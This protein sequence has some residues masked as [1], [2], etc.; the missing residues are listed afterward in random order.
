MNEKSSL[1]LSSIYGAIKALDQGAY[2]G[3]SYNLT[4][5]NTLN[6]DSWWVFMPYGVWGNPPKPPQG[7]SPL[8]SAML[9]AIE[10]SSPSRCC[11]DILHLFD[12]GGEDFFAD[13]NASK[14]IATTLVDFLN[15]IPDAET[16]VIRYLVGNLGGRPDP[17][18]DGFMKALFAALGRKPHKARLFFGNFAPD[19]SFD[20]EL[21][22]QLSTITD[23]FRGYLDSEGANEN[24][25]KYGMAIPKELANI[26]ELTDWTKQFA[27]YILP[28]ASWNHAKIFA[29]N[30]CQL[31]TGGANYWNSW[32][33][34][35]AKW[36]FDLSMNV[37]GDTAVDAHQF[38]NYLWKYLGDIPG[39]DKIS[40]CMENSTGKIAEWS[41]KGKAPQF[42]DFPENVGTTAALTVARNGNWPSLRGFPMQV[43]DGIRDF[44]I[45]VLAVV[46]ETRLGP[47]NPVTPFAVRGLDDSNA[48]FRN[49]LS[50]V[51]INPAAWASRYARNYAISQAQSSVRFSQQK[52]VMD[53]L[54]D[55]DTYKKLIAE[56]NKALKI[57]WNGYVWP[58]DTLSA[59]GYA[60]ANISRS[61]PQSNGIQIV[62]STP[63]AKEN[64]EDPVSGQEFKSKLTGMMAG[65]EALG[66]ITFEGKIPDIVEKWLTY[67]RVDTKSSEAEHGNHSKLVVVDDAVCY[68][69]S[70][71][72]YPCYN[73]EFG[74]WIDDKQA[75]SSFVRDYWNGLW[76]FARAAE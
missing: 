29:I 52:F 25:G 30:G 28:A 55:R 61:A 75:I 18:S 71:N 21:E 39:S 63:S 15:K 27:Q 4:H 64:Y 42:A 45:N 37:S 16:P 32:Y 73:E 5:H 72:A 53:D 13:K 46:A 41:D 50:K 26:S 6:N 74:I 65:M 59:L 17:R 22:Q 2:E 57:N 58:F 3:F 49:A 54:A 70:D 24:V 66:Y 12:V 10:R 47:G 43:A 23:L 62:S 76:A 11:I 40:C 9:E 68:V 69:G 8:E 60:L 44:F 34:T 14:Q 31:V 19:I 51:R 1:S 35:G 20:T 7:S 36:L 67:R 48:W 38:A 33:T 56:I